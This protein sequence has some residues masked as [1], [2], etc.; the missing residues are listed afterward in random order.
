M[1]PALFIDRDGTLCHDCPYC[2]NEAEI[3]MY[4]DIF[5]PLK[6]LSQNYYIIV[7][8][9]QS[10][11]GRGY[12]TLADLDKMNSK[13]KTEIESRGGRVDAIYYCPHIPQDYCDCRKPKTGMLEKAMK[14]FDIDTERSFVVGDD[15]SDIGF[16]MNAGIRGIRVRREG[17]LEG[18]FFAEDFYDVLKIINKNSD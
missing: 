12:F 13:V 11:V 1:K 6:E 5:E 3:L 18:D 4:D 9:N 16:A 7:V 10:G 17:E 2:K 8:T 15:D 14:D